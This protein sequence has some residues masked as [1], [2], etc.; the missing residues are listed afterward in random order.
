[1]GGSGHIIIDEIQSEDVSTK[2][3]KKMKSMES[4]MWSLLLQH[5]GI[6]CLQKKNNT[7]A[8]LPWNLQKLGTLEE[9]SMV[10][11]E[12]I[13]LSH[14]LC[15]RS[16]FRRSLAISFSTQLTLTFPLCSFHRLITFFSF[17]LPS[18]YGSCHT[19]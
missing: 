10:C 18:T 12:I 17:E 6:Y 15:R 3:K 11:P 16:T 7:L 19:A 9:G 1:M 5:L 14:S 2:L 13:C 8:K 4:S